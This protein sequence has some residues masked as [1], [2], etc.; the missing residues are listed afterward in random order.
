MERKGF[1]RIC[2]LEVGYGGAPILQNFGLALAEG[3]ITGLLGPNG[4]G[5][6]TLVKTIIGLKKARSGEIRLGDPGY[7]PGEI[8]FQ[9]LL[10][11]V[12][13]EL[14]IC[15]ELSAL[16]NLR[17]FGNL[18]GLS[19]EV[20]EKRSHDLLSQVGLLDRA[21]Q[22]AGEF[23]G[24]MQRRLNLAVAVVH[25]PKLLILD[26]PTVGV[27]PQSRYQMLDLIRE[28]N[29]KGMTVLY[30]SHFL[31]EAE[32]LCDELVIMDHGK[33]LAQ[34]SLSQLLAGLPTRVSF[35]MAEEPSKSLVQNLIT[36]G[37][38]G[39]FPRDGQG[40]LMI[41]LPADSGSLARFLALLG[42]TDGVL[43]GFEAEKPRL[44]TLFLKL[45]GRQFR[46]E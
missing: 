7:A 27:D 9:R 12:P 42:S 30:T 13:Q 14:A 10:G 18:F 40:R 15:P 23:S 6:T 20:L 34:G 21:N 4:A 24:G 37:M 33:I 17:F 31:D 29:Q 36:L 43:E 45:T 46:D 8:G 11:V 2:D 22:V 16:E 5:K 44:E 28:W 38:K 39:P 35:Q 26:E 25:G 19:G 32:R 3:K 1:L 41:E